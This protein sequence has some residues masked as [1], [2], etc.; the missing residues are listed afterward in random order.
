MPNL[1]YFLIYKYITYILKVHINITLQIYKFKLKMS[2]L[3]LKVECK[4]PT[5]FHFVLKHVYLT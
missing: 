1:I 4:K 2:K 5:S 3:I